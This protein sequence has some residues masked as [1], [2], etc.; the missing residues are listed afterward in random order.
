MAVNVVTQSSV[1]QA[2]TTPAVEIKPLVAFIPTRLFNAA[3][4]RPEPAVSVP[5]EKLATL[6]ATANEEPA[7]EP[8]DGYSG[9]TLFGHAPYGERLPL[10]PVAN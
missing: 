10:R 3:G 6:S 2:G 5:N 8:P 4:T 9:N 7:L 1:R